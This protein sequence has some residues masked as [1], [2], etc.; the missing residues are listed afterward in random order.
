ME[1]QLEASSV[2]LLL[3]QKLGTGGEAEIYAVANEERLA[4]KIYHRPNADRADKLAAMLADPP[5]DPMAA[6][7][8]VSIAWPTARLLSVETSEVIGYLMPRIDEARLIHELYNPRSRQRICPLFHYGYLLR[9]ARNLA[10]AVRA[11]HERGYVIGDL[12]ESNV[13]VTTQ[14]LVTLVDT[15]SFQVRRNGRVHRCP[16]GKAEYTPPEL[17]GARFADV[18]RGPEHD[19]FALA[20]LIFQ[21]LMQGTHP[22]AGVFSGHGEPAPIGRRIQAGHWPF[23]HK[24]KSPYHPNPHAPAWGV[25]P[26][27]VQELMWACFEEGHV[28]PSRRPSAVAWQ[29]ALQESEQSLVSCHVNPQHLFHKG[30]DGCPWCDIARRTGRDPFPIPARLVNTPAP[31]P[32][33]ATVVFDVN[34]QLADVRTEGL[35]RRRRSRK[36]NL[37]VA[38]AVTLPTRSRRRPLMPLLSEHEIDDDERSAFWRW[39][40]IGL[41]LLAATLLAAAAYFW[42]Q[43]RRPAALVDELALLPDDCFIVVSA[44]PADILA[45]NLYARIQ[46]DDPLYRSPFERMIREGSG[47]PAKDISQLTVAFCADPLPFFVVRTRR[48]INAE[49][50]RLSLASDPPGPENAY[51]AISFGRYVVYEPTGVDP[52]A[53]RPA[54]CVVNNQFVVVGSSSAIERVLQRNRNARLSATI[55]AAWDSADFSKSLTLLIDVAGLIKGTTHSQTIPNVSTFQEIMGGI[56]AAVADVEFD[57]QLRVQARIFCNN[58]ARASDVAKQLLREWPLLREVLPE[59]D[60]PGSVVD[61][62]EFQVSRQKQTVMVS[63]SLATETLIEW[64]KLSSQ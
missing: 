18:D 57:S 61:S 28:D 55:K 10:A 25:L 49:T 51:H 64:L 23:S 54:F 35:P 62:V 27:A 26:V 12:N 38:R 59:W 32:E 43:T 47:I 41:L 46:A 1:V 58:E 45:S 40:W 50:I 37:P 60:V 16:V 44:R 48:D 13:L 8:H 42:W 6:A 22:F 52:P 17:Q 53:Q 31:I 15:D 21:L 33:D 7:G 2:K 11:L 56:D 30:L 9:T 3:D 24:K 5:D 36:E 29:R 63:F 20:V 4:A 39:L 14:A 19:V 34:Q